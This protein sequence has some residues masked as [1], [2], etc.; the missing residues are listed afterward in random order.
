MSKTVTPFI[1]ELTAHSNPN[2][3]HREYEPEDFN[4]NIQ[5]CSCFYT[6]CCTSDHYFGHWNCLLH[7]TQKVT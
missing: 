5:I 2:F 6:S 1:K 3:L 4:N 7:K